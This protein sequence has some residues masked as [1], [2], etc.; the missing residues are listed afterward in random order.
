MGPLDGGFSD[1]IGNYPLVFGGS[2]PSCPATRGRHYWSHL[3]ELLNRRLSIS[4]LFLYSAVSLLFGYLRI[5]ADGSRATT[6]TANNVCRW[7]NGET[8]NSASG[9]MSENP[10]RACIT[11]YFLRNICSL[12][13]TFP[14]EK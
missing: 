6:G 10:S 5:S 2:F 8:I 7:K 4:S 14:E 12:S 9:K 1:D 13:N 3:R 11:P